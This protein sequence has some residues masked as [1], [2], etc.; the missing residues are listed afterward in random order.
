MSEQGGCLGVST[1]T[2]QDEGYVTVTIRDDGH[3]IDAEHLPR[4][5]DPFFTTKTDGT[6]TGLGL[7]IVRSIVAAHGG[8]IRADLRKPRGTIFYVDL[9]IAALSSTSAR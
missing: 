9:P 1:A 3:G 5:F 2:S 7:S 6:G 4:I 8:Q